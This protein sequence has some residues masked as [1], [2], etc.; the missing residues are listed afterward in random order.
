MTGLVFNG[1]RVAVPGVTVLS[2]G[3]EPWCALDPADCRARRTPWVRQIVIHTTGGY[4]HQ[5]IK[6]GSGPGGRARSVANFWRGDPVHSGAHL[7]VDSDGTVACLAD[8]SSICAYHATVSN[9]WSIG[10]EMAQE[11]DGGIYEATIVST[12]VVS[13]VI[14]DHLGIPRQFAADP[15]DGHPIKRLLDGGPLVVGVYGHRNNTE[16]RGWGDPGDEI[17]K[18]LASAG[19]LGVRL[20]YDEDIHIGKLRQAALNSRGEGLVI[21]GVLGPVSI[22]AM[23]RQGF[24]TWSDVGG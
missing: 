7:V 15:Y 21:D 18:E 19:W 14:A 6:L 8:L 13:G 10:I 5:H 22:A 9:E 4:P 24:A 23:R 3:D 2:P 11:P 20:G 17:F 1:E 16:N 12:V